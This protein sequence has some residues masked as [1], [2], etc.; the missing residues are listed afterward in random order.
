M[1]GEIVNLVRTR[2]GGKCPNVWLGT[3]IGACT[4]IKA[5]RWEPYGVNRV[6]GHPNLVTLAAE[7][8]S[9]ARVSNMLAKCTQKV[10]GCGRGKHP[11]TQAAGEAKGAC[12]ARVNRV[13]AKG[14]VS[15]AYYSDKGSGRRRP[16]IENTKRILERHD[17]V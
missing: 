11:L 3:R 7:S 2:A 9:A 15:D 12:G 4:A 5:S 16:T 14:V 1:C 6:S 8:H 13:P 17:D 10:P